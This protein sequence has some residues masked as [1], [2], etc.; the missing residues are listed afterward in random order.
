MQN[1][2]SINFDKFSKINKIIIS[3]KNGSLVKSRIYKK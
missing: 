2:F 1:D 3:D